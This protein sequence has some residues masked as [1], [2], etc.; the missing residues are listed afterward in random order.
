[1]KLNNEKP[2]QGIQSIEVGAR[3]LEALA[4]APRS[5]MLR[6]LAAKADMSP[7]KAYR[8]LVSFIRMGLVAQ[9]HDCGRYTL[10]SFSLQLG[11]SALARM[12][13]VTL[14]T[15][16]AFLTFLPRNTTARFLEQEFVDNHRH[17][18]S[19]VSHAGD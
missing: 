12:E 16:R 2:R 9:E 11:L 10:G 15:G 18:L 19:P 3:L 14:A 17:G 8:Y 1:M 4:F 5:V 13:P 7:S 6:D